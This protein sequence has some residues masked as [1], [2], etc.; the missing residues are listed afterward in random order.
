MHVCRTSSSL[1]HEKFGSLSRAA[2][3]LNGGGVVL[4][5]TE[6]VWGLA[7][8]CDRGDA[9]RRIVAIKARAA[10]KGLIL[11]GASHDFFAVEL[12]PLGESDRREIIGSWPAAVTWVLP[13]RRFGPDITGG[14]DT[15]AVRV[16]EHPQA[17]ALADLVGVPLVSTSANRSGRPA[18]RNQFV[19]ARN[20]RRDVDYLLPGE[21]L[22]RRS[23]SE[24][25]TI[26]GQ[27]LRGA[28]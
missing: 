4:H 12:E 17:R 1:L 11:I 25:R 6:G 9:I 13:N 16:P 28:G 18:A 10:A 2:Q 8:R 26:R 22:G 3:I 27:V 5:A 23:P 24:I 14:R 21:T 19:A 15:V 20:L 7:C